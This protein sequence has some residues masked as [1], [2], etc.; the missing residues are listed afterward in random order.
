VILTLSD[1]W[2]LGFDSD[3][4]NDWTFESV[5]RKGYNIAA[6]NRRI[7]FIDSRHY[8]FAGYKKAS[9]LTQDVFDS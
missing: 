4:S 5:I 2:Q 8:L 3:D 6:P 1:V 9:G 7:S